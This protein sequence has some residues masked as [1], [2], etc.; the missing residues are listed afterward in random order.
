MSSSG[1]G[2][3][4]PGG[5]SFEAARQLNPSIVYLSVTG[6]GQT[7][8]LKDKAGHAGLVGGANQIHR[9]VL[10]NPLHASP[11]GLL[12]PDAD[13]SQLYEGSQAFAR[14]NSYVW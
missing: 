10:F 8:E 6:Y 3:W 7:G 4:L 12:V 13:L 2:L 9:S 14:T 1:R 11:S 5:L